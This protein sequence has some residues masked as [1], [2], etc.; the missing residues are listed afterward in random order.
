MKAIYK[1]ENI[2]NKRIYIGSTKNYEKRKD[3]HFRTLRNNNHHNDF[4]QRSF[5]KHG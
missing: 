1:I 5:N 4:L 3:T 2:V